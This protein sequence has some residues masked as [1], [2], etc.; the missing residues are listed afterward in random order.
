MLDN[1]YSQLEGVK[2]SNSCNIYLDN[3]TAHNK[4]VE[5]LQD[6]NNV[7]L[8]NGE[9][10]KNGNRF[11]CVTC[12]TSLGHYSV[13]QR[14]K[15]KMHLDNVEGKDTN[16]IEDSSISEDLRSSFTDKTDY[17]NICNGRYHNKK[18]TD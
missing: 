8:N 6:K 18:E 17:C 9:I 13:E 16:I 5:T 3:N 11:N 1:Q 14:F 15:T 12:K 7:K 2:Y 10:L 4:H